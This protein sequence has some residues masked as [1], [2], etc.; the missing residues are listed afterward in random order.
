MKFLYSIQYIPGTISLMYFFDHDNFQHLAVRRCNESLMI[1][2]LHDCDYLPDFL[3][4]DYIDD[5]ETFLFQES[6]VWDKRINFHALI[7][8]QKQVKYY[9]DYL[10]TQ[11]YIE[12]EI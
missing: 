4:C 12:V 1:E 5:H 11:E 9:W 6:L 7:E 2:Y 10:I 8:I 3:E